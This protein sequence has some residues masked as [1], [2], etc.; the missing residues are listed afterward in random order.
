MSD[1]TK[2]APKEEEQDQGENFYDAKFSI[3]AMQNEPYQSGLSWRTIVGALF[4]SFVMLPGVIFMGLMIGTDIGGAAEWVTIILF[5][6]LAR[7][8]FMVLKKQ[9]IYMLKY[10]VAQ[11]THIAGGL[12]VGGGVFAWLVV[13]RYMRNSEAFKNFGIAD[14][15]PDWFSPMG[16]RAYAAFT[17]LSVW[18]P[19]IGVLVGSMVLSKLTMLSLGF[20]LYKITADVERLPFP[21]APIHAEGAI[22]LAE[23]SKDAK[24]K[25]YRQ[26]CFS[27]GIIIGAVFGIF[28][29][30]IPTLSQAFLGKTLQFIPI[31][32]WDMTLAYE[33][34]LTKM[35]GFPL[36]GGTL[37][38]SLNLGLIFT[39]FVLPWRIVIGMFV[40]NIAVQ[41]F[42]NPVLYAYGYMPNWSPGKDAI[43]THVASTLDLYLS[44]GI[45]TSLAVF[46][47]GLYGMVKA[48]LKFSRNKDP[49]KKIEKGS[50]WHRDVERGDP[51]M[52]I[53]IG[54]WVASSI[55]FIVLSDILV[56][57]GVPENER[58]S[59]WWF[60]A[61][62]FLITPFQSY[63]NAR[64]S[65]IAGQNVGIPFVMES[66][67]FSS[68]FKGVSIWFAPLPLHNYGSMADHL[69][70]VQLTRTRFTSI[71]W[72]ELLVFP[73][74]LIASFIFWTYIL[75]LGPIPSDNYPYVAKFW[76]QATQMKAL[77]AA[78]MQE[79][80]SLL[81]EALK[82]SLIGFS[83]IALTL[84]F[85][86]FGFFGISAQY[87]YGGIGA[88]NGYPHMIIM[89]FIGALL[90]RYV[91]RKKF[92]LE[93]WTN[94]APILAV[95]FG[96]GLGLIGMLSIALNFLWVSIGTTY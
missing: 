4:V 24:T 57:S 1:A 55:G 81:T 28:Y 20:I 29:V 39:G 47:V 72:I 13:N 63:V 59:I 37:G 22:A 62:A 77:W 83:A 18:G 70:E 9:E 49:Q 67:I 75:T 73:L 10:T 60:V 58:F 65:G 91:F 76:P 86:L 93:S 69:R 42:L 33:Q 79:G 5:V 94:Y 27:L 11:L 14:S 56:N 35:A 52:W 82:P 51:P 16:D 23:T 19:A 7:R 26:T 95:G 17:D 53:A 8:S 90:G 68:G 25:N 3:E 44:V 48:L 54:V 43:Q 45:G 87:I 64:M 66:A 96:A 71:L 78:S 40:T 36:G 46:F 12:S 74:L 80:S 38:I 41:I 61:F 50:F 2:D 15:T 30:A 31:P 21:L 88:V 92:G 32:F 84:L 34:F 6:E 85:S 89:M